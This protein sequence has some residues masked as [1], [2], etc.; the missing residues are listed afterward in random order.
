[1]VPPETT[2]MGLFRRRGI[3]GRD[4]LVGRTS[5]RPLLYPPSFGLLIASIIVTAIALVI[6]YTSI[7]VPIINSAYV[8][9]VLLIGYAILL[10]AVLVGRRL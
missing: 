4:P 9:E 5:A 8:F 7:D 1:M 6:R 2:P 10:F 3:F